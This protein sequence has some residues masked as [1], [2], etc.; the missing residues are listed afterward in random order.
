MKVAFTVRE[1]LGDE[2]RYSAALRYRYGQ[3][4]VGN[5][6]QLSYNRS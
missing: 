2:Q 5:G 1:E 3:N 6:K 4:M